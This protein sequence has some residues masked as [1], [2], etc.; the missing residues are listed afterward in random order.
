MYKLI[1]DVKTIHRLSDNAWIPFAPDNTDYAQFKSAILNG[2]AT[3]QDADGTPM[4]SQAAIT[5][6]TSLP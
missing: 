3:L 6:V 1:E 5:Y 2:T 4:T